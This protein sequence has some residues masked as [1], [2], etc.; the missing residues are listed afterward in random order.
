MKTKT[1]ALQ[2]IG[3]LVTG[4]ILALSGAK[5]GSFIAPKEALLDLEFGF[6]G[7]FLAYPIGILFAV[8]LIGKYSRAKGSIY[9]SIAGMGILWLAF[10]LGAEPLKLIAEPAAIISFFALAGPAAAIIGYYAFEDKIGKK[11]NRRRN[12]N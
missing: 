9:F 4:V 6:M 2:Y 5:I 1:V 7:A 12:H 3:G 8:Y 10:I 11:K